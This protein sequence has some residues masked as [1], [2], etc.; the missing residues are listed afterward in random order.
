MCLLSSKEFVWIVSESSEDVIVSLA[1]SIVH[2]GDD[3]LGFADGILAKEKRDWVG[4][5]A[6]ITKIRMEE[7]FSLR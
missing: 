6:E 2:F 1:E 7:Y 4:V 5:V 3:C